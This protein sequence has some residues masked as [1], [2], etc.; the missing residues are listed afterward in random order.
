MD[1]RIFIEPQQG[2][3]YEEQA[4]FAVASETAGLDG[5]FR[6][7]HYLSMGQSARA[8]IGP[9]DAWVTLGAIARETS[10]IRLGSLMTAATFRYPGPLAI[11]VAQV[12]AMS[13]GRVEFGLGAG[14]YEEEHRA[15]GIP[16][17]ASFAE[18]LSRLEEQLEIISGIWATPRGS[19]FQFGGT[20]YELKDCPALPK[21]AQEKLPIIVGGKGPRR[22]PALAARFADEF[23]I[24]FVSAE[25]AA[26]S[27]GALDRACEQ[28]GRNP[29]EIVR[30]VALTTLIGSDHAECEA[31]AMRV[32][33]AYEEV[34]EN[35][36]AGTPDEIA[37]RLA[38]YARV[39]VSRVYLQLLDLEDLEQIALIGSEL[40]SKVS[41]I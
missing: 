7:D 16:F 17:G 11:S 30:S 25:F 8:G 39:G 4:R 34:Q 13:N 15:Y 20:Y 31:R 3:T 2:A 18:R 38:D 27:F 29:R 35:G 23:N 12:D 32:G 24:P 21:P 26:G 40:L 6:S 9:T 19:S 36:L 33:R 10:R 28:R 5:F 41:G 22:T 37:E 14:W 1:L